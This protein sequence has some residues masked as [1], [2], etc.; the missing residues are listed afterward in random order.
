MDD[1]PG[2]DAGRCGHKIEPEDQH[3]DDVQRAANARIQYIGIIRTTVSTKSRYTQR[4]VRR[5]RAPHEALRHAGPVDR[6]DVE[7]DAERRDPEMHLRQLLAVE[8]RAENARQQPVH[9]AERQEAV[10]ASAPV[11]TW[12]MTQSV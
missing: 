2:C 4:A 11:W 8:L 1:S 6:D 9:H 5:E 10:P 7:Q 12:A 3:A